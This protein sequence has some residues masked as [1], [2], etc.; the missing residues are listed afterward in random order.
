MFCYN[1]HVCVDFCRF[2]QTKQVLQMEE[3]VDLE[4]IQERENAIKQLEVSCC[5][6]LFSYHFLSVSCV[7]NLMNVC[8]FV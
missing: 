8:C 2:S 3:D 4:M 1:I 6:A 5:K 7:N